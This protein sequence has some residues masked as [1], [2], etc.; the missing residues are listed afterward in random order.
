MDR[1]LAV[2]RPKARIAVARKLST[3]L[4]ALWRDN[5]SFAPFPKGTPRV[6]GQTHRPPTVEDGVGTPFNH[7]GHGDPEASVVELGV[8]DLLLSALTEKQ[9]ERIKREQRE[10]VE[11]AE[12]W[13]QGT[14][15]RDIAARLK[16]TVSTVHR[17]LPEGWST[18]GKQP[19]TKD[20]RAYVLT[21]SN[22]EPIWSKQFS[23]VGK[24]STVHQ[25]LIRLVAEGILSRVGNGA[26][27]RV[28]T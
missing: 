7:V 28:A 4:F 5:T 12:L 23:H 9:R 25:A 3:I 14:S 18:V 2:G 1:A 11:A 6:I 20:I 22:G 17:R 13:S 16:L 27:V 10:R 19:V 21:L 24:R 8:T 15:V 26:W